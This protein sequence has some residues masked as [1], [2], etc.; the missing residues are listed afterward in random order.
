M[1]AACHGATG[2]GDGQQAMK[3]DAGWPVR[4]RD[5]TRG[6]FKGGQDAGQLFARI[7]LG[8]PGSPM[9]PAAES[10]PDASVGDLIHFI[11]SL[12][13][14]GVAARAEHQR[15]QIVAR[16]TQSG[17]EGDVPDA[18]WEGA[19]AVPVVVT[20][21]WWREYAEPNLHV[22]AL[23]DGTTLAVRLTWDDATRD[24]AALRPQDF[25]DMAAVQFFKGD[26]E[27]FLGMGALD[28][29]VDVWLWQAGRTTE[30]GSP[31]DLDKSYPNMIVDGY[32]FEKPADG[33]PAL[34]RQPPEFLTALAAGNLRA[35]PTR[36]GSGDNLSATGFG[37]LTLRPKLSQVVKA[38]AR[39][40]DGKWTVV[41]RRPLGVDGKD[42][43]SLAPGEPLSLALAVWDGSAGDR[44]GQKFVSIW[45]GFRLEE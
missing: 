21:L 38:Q 34:E 23:H 37:S 29:G 28:A 9:P 18:A 2:K 44:N 1:C 30:D 7:R 43:L 6:V 25:E 11:H 20:P 35:D 27:P 39:W 32:P 13:P 45:H 17:L 22:A 3:D 42:G 14:P 4:P 24:G 40:K 33:K 12:E 36:A 15:M 10:V 26:E 5:F 19:E 31:A 41:L 8:M 16:R